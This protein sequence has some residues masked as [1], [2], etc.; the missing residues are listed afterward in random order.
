MTFNARTE[1]AHHEILTFIR[2]HSHTELINKMRTHP[3]FMFLLFFW[4][5][6]CGLCVWVV[7]REINARNCAN[8]WL[9]IEIA[10]QDLATFKLNVMIFRI[11]TKWTLAIWRDS[12]NDMKKIKTRTKYVW[13]IL[14]C[15]WQCRPII[16]TTPDAGR[17]QASVVRI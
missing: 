2:I 5:L 17:S 16:I 9:R 8:N 11:S 15:W 14:F 6:A 7:L 12:G 4:H 1:W 3:C 13:T 10:W